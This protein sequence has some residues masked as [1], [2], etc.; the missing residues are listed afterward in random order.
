MGRFGFL[1]AELS[2]GEQ[3]IG[4][5]AS[6]IASSRCRSKQAAHAR[7][8]EG[9]G[10]EG[11]WGLSGLACCGITVGVAVV[12][13]VDGARVVVE[14]VVALVVVVAI[15]VG[16]GLVT[17]DTA[18]TKDSVEEV[19]EEDEEFPAAWTVVVVVVVLVV[20]VVDPLEVSES[21]AFSGRLRQLS[22]TETIGSLAEEG[23]E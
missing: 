2:I 23:P 14:A 21:S 18:D 16:G 8:V 11:R 10:S 12:A 20:A 7:E 4:Q 15:V 3:I 5:V 9:R 17:R 1:R 19:G 13:G 22:T 6:S